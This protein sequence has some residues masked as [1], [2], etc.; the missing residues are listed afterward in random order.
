MGN[1]QDYWS[2]EKTKWNNGYGIEDLVTFGINPIKAITDII[3]DMTEGNSNNKIPCLNLIIRNMLEN[4]E[5][6][7]FRLMSERTDKPEEA[8]E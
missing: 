7:I 3:D 6:C 4:M 5:R 8:T 2:L 1:F